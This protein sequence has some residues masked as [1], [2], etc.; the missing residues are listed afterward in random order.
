MNPLVSYYK[1]GLNLGLLPLPL[2][3]YN[4]KIIKRSSWEVLWKRA[5]PKDFHQILIQEFWSLKRWEEILLKAKSLIWWWQVFLWIT[6][7]ELFMR[8]TINFKFILRLLYAYNKKRSI[9]RFLSVFIWVKVASSV[10]RLHLQK[11]QRYRNAILPSLLALVTLGT[12]I[13]NLWHRASQHNRTVH[14]W[15]QCRKATVLSCHRCLINTGVEK[16]NT[17]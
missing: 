5:L 13:D 7:H 10:V 3:S 17:I 2:H 16:M 1:N 11:R 4:F 12:G 9:S 8:L 15:H 14:I 6:L